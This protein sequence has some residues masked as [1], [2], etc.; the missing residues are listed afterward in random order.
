[1]MKTPFF[2]K[3]IIIGL[4]LWIIGCF[5]PGFQE[6]TNSALWIITITAYAA[7][8]NLFK[9]W[10]DGTKDK[11]AIRFATVVNGTTAVKMLLTLSIITVYLATG[12]QNPV[13][14]VFGVFVVFICYTTLFVSDTQSEIRKG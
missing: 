13:Q 1:M 11:S 4:S 12:Q 5:V 10:V 9:M 6:V 8:T 2:V 7:I 3:T 14:Y